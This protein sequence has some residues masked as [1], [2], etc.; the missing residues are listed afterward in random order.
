MKH[1]RIDWSGLKG[2]GS[3]RVPEFDVCAMLA[4][5]M[6]QYPGARFQLYPD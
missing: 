2:S 4:H 1:Y 5:L 6:K 3:H